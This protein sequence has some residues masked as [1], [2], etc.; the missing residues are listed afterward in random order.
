MPA[1]RMNWK[2]KWHPPGTG[3]PVVSESH[4]RCCFIPFPRKPWFLRVCSASLLKTLREK[5]KL[6]V[7]SNFSFS[8]SVFYSFREPSDIFIK[9]KKCCLQTLSFW[10]SLKFVVW[11]RIISLPHNHMNLYI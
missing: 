4:N 3:L 6:L 1:Y 10:K 8:H 5:K 2:S 7:M 11:E 9:F